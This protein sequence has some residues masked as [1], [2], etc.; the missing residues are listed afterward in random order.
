MGLWNF[1]YRTTLVW[2]K[3]TKAGQ[4]IRNGQGWWFR[5]AAEYVLVGVRQGRSIPSNLRE[6]TVFFA[7]R[8]GK[9][10]EKPM[11][12]YDL[13][14]RVEPGKSKIDVFARNQRHGWWVYGNELGPDPLP[15]PVDDFLR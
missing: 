5:N 2:V 13:I 14:D 10:S 12:F 6:P 1:K 3:V 4:V 7:E 9:H 8:T 15:P 11:A